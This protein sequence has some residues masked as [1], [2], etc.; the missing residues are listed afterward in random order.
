MDEAATQP[1]LSEEELAALVDDPPERIALLAGSGCT[2]PDAD[3]G[4]APGDAHR[5]RVVD[6]FE[7]AGVPLDVLIR[8]QDA[9]LISVAYYDELHPPPGRPSNRTYAA[10]L[11]SLGSTGQLVS[12]ALGAMGI[13]EPDATSRLTLEDEAFLADLGS[14]LADAGQTDLVL[15]VLRQFG[16]AARRASVA[17][18]ETYAE[19]IDR[20]GP[21]FAG[22]P[23]RAVFDEHFLPWARIARGLPGVAEWLTTRHMTR[24]I[25]RYSLESTEQTL[26]S[27]GYV[28][29]RR[30]TDPA[31][32]FADLTGFT[33]LAEQRGDATAADVALRLAELAG[34]I[35]EIHG[36]RVVK[37]LGDGVL[38]RFGGA[39]S[40]ADASL[41]LLD[42]LAASDLPAGHIGV[43][44]GPIIARDG[45]IFGRTVNLAARI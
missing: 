25:D 5:V 4:Y 31:V 15:R 32:A 9:G 37:L 23:S 1:T 44:E 30:G 39:V 34:G 35:A 29:Q 7:A 26:A 38:M 40:A 21:E 33:A 14:M 10:F 45:D 17:A 2:A 41:D 28:P 11:A 24:E 12:A 8:A 42:R 18:L 36:G 16:E 13:A 22:V 20:L 19:L 3:G 6:G 27:S 43:A